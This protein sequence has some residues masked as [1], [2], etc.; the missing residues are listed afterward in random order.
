MAVS[1]L[2]E[3]V[4]DV[5][6]QFGLEQQFRFISHPGVMA[7]SRLLEMRTITRMRA[8]FTQENIEGM[9]AFDPDLARKAQIAFDN[10][11]PVNFQQ[12]ELIE[13]SLPRL[14][15]EK[16]QLEKL[17]A[18]VA[19]LPIGKYDMPKVDISAARPV[20]GQKDLQGTLGELA[21]VLHPGS[22]DATTKLPK[23]LK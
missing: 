10:K 19:K 20:P 22:I 16:T 6:V 5:F 14:L 11:L 3:K 7:V 15:E 1:R 9:K 8:N 12:L 4:P 2:L 18:E 13:E 23:Q 17:R 21:E